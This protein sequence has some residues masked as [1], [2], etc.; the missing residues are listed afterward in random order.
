MLEAGATGS[1]ALKE[2]VLTTDVE[3]RRRDQARASGPR[4]T[5]RCLHACELLGS[6][7]LLQLPGLGLDLE[8]DVA[9]RLDRPHPRN[10]DVVVD[11]WGGGG[12]TIRGVGVHR[13]T[14]G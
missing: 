9:H 14:A 7:G 10:R 2:D 8:T 5:A 1:T 6:A 3:Y 4:T 13:V 12:A 11:R